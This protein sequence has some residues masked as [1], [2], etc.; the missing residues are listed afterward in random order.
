MIVCEII[1]VIYMGNFVAAFLTT[2]T[3]FPYCTIPLSG[4]SLEW[5]LHTAINTHL[6]IKFK[7]VTFPSQIC[8]T[9][10]NKKAD[11]GCSFWEFGSDFG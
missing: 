5:L 3:S 7:E 2:P 10:Q 9:K 8:F 4:H 1:Y 11:K 6:P